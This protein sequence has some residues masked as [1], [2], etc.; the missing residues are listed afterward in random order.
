MEEEL[1]VRLGR[2]PMLDP[3]S[4]R[5]LRESGMTIGAHT[6]T[7]PILAGLDDTRARAE[8]HDSR[9]HLA[10]IL[11]EPIRVFAYPNG[12]PGR[13]YLT[14][15]VDMVVQAGFKAAV[16]TSPLTARP[17]MNHYELPRFTPWGR[18]GW[19]FAARLAQSRMSVR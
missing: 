2:G 7:H 5:R 1:D 12:L 11:R 8:I 6:V 14:K 10:E 3:Q 16:S 9:D 17:G 15:H 13:D 4:V 19:R 18:T